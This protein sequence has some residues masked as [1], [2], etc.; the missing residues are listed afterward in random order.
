MKIKVLM[1]GILLLVIGLI[2]LAEGLHLVNNVD[3][4]AVKDVVGPGYYILSVS[5]ILMVIGIV[6][7]LMN[8]RIL[9]KKVTLSKEQATK[10]ISMIVIHMTVVLLIYIVLIYIFGYLFSTLVFFFLEFRL[11]GVKS[12]KSNVVLAVAV[13]AVFYFVF[14]QYCNLVFPHGLFSKFLP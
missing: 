5:I 2:C 12:F 10:K 9:V 7:L 8:R 3:P 1:E 4:D 11:A 6:Y 14:I 13:S